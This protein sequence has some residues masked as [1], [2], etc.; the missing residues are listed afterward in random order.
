MHCEL[1]GIEHKKLKKV[2][3]EGSILAVCER[4]MRYGSSYSEPVSQIKMSTA[5]IAHRLELRRK[6]LIDKNIFE[7][8]KA[9]LMHD[10]TR[11]IRAARLQLGLTPEQLGKKINEK[12]TVINKLESGA[13]VPDEKLIKKL[14]RA[15]SIKLLEKRNAI[16]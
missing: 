1:C 16:V 8:Q 7:E 12:K 9:D 2:M 11:R 4:C 10:Y 15:L 5:E 13:M 14:E 6:F 3:I